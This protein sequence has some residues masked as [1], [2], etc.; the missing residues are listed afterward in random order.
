MCQRPYK[1]RFFVIN[2]QQI[3]NCRSTEI[4]YVTR[5]QSQA[6]K[7]FSKQGFFLAIFGYFYAIL[8]RFG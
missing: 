3:I 7:V 5:D 8:S 4:A 1:P 6:H 2:L